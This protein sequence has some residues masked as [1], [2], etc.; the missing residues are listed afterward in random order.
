MLYMSY[1]F[2]IILALEYICTLTN[3]TSLNSPMKF[4]DPY[5]TGYPSKEFPEGIFIFPWFL[6]IDFLRDN[7]A[8]AHFFSIDIEPT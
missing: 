4:P 8:W 3:L 6:K 1:T 2:G 7:L 5:N